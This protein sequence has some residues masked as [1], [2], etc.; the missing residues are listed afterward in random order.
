MKSAI[1]ECS[2]HAR[3]AVQSLQTQI[4]WTELSQH[5]ERSRNIAVGFDEY[6]NTA[7]FKSHH[8]T[9]AFV[10]HVYIS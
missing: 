3:K 10:I 5:F 7:I 1:K 2:E 9:S 8:L 4:Q 6:H